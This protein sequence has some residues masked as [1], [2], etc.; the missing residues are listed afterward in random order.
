MRVPFYTITYNVI[1]TTCSNNDNSHNGVLDVTFLA[2]SWEDEY[3]RDVD[4]ETNVPGY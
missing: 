4:S 2:E 1:S 3:K